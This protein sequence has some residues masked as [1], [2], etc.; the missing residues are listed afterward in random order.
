MWVQTLAGPAADYATRM[1]QENKEMT[2]EGLKKKLED[3]YNGTADVQFARQQLRRLTQ[4]ADESIQNYYE[5]IMLIASNA[6]GASE[7]S[8]KHVE[9]QLIDFFVDGLRDDHLVRRL[10]RKSP[11]TLDEAFKFASSEQ[12]AQRSYDL[13]RGR[14]DPE[15]MEVDVLAS[16]QQLGCQNHFDAS[17]LMINS[18]LRQQLEQKCEVIEEMQ[19]RLPP[20]LRQQLNIVMGHYPT[21][22]RPNWNHQDR[23]HQRSFNPLQQNY[24]L[25]RPNQPIRPTRNHPDLRCFKC[26]EFGHFASTCHF[27]TTRFSKNE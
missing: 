9:V 11:K 3:H 19:E 13:R 12:Q 16:N 27:Q 8:D 26:G 18:D 14:A 2:W 7:I 4:R 21:H 17:L 23:Q 6:F 22:Q 25:P 15:P 1:I 10:L 20:E 24:T 5:R